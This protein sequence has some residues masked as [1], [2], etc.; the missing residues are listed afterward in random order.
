MNFEWTKIGDA[1]RLIE[2][3][4]REGWG[5]GLPLIRPSDQSV[6]AMAEAVAQGPD[7]I[8]G[9]V[10]PR[11]RELSMKTAAT[12]SVAA[13]CQ[14]KHFPVVLGACQAM[15]DPSFG[16]HA[17]QTT[18][19]PCAVLIIVSGPV[20][21]DV[22]INS[23][24][25]CLGPG[26]RANATI[27][28]AV[29]LILQA[30]GGAQPGLVDRATHGHPGKFTYCLAENQRETPWEPMAVR[31]NLGASESIVTVFAGEAP[32]N[33]QE[34]HASS[35]EEILDALSSVTTGVVPLM[36]THESDTLF[37]L[38]PEH[39]ALLS[40]A[41]FDGHRVAAELFRRITRPSSRTAGESAEAA[42][43]FQSSQHPAFQSPHNVLV[44]VAGGAG[45]HSLWIPSFGHSRAVSRTML[46]DEA[47]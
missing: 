44:L 40:E 2:A 24:A 47:S 12:F 35:A 34:H 11:Q 45:K 36:H 1:H 28:R 18:T 22:A 32:L 38:C 5:D 33:V 4:L 39:A 42:T 6:S 9:Q 20:T 16:L 41:G 17:V 14:P 7:E 21:E 15:L 8:I 26:C 10:P 43:N 37:V 23:G 31:R 13:G 3:S 46:G 27:G 29:R 30:A 25:G 19:S